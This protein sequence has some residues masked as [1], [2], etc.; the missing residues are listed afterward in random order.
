MTDISNLGAMIRWPFELIG[1]IL[2]FIIKYFLEIAIVSGSIWLI[3][4]IFRS[5]LISR[6]VNVIEE[7]KLKKKQKENVI[8]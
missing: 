8:S 6:I 4:W 5:G 1:D 7:N 3:F 2:H